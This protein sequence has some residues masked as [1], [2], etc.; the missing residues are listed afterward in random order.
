M[1]FVSVGS[2]FAHGANFQPVEEDWVLVQ[3]TGDC[4]MLSSW[5]QLDFVTS[6]TLSFKGK[7]NIKSN[8]WTPS[9]NTAIFE[10]VA[11]HSG[12]ILLFGGV[13]DTGRY[14]A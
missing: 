9:E 3:P 10:K 1:V 12:P 4:L 7:K 2:T 14:V 6:L 13:F 8:V 5:L 11:C